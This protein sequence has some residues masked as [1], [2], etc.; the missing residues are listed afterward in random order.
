MRANRQPTR[1]KM[2]IILAHVSSENENPLKKKHFN[3]NNNDNV[4]EVRIFSVVVARQGEGKEKKA[5]VFNTRFL[6]SFIHFYVT[7]KDFLFNNFFFFH[8]LRV[9]HLFLGL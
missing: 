7:S 4:T 6:H 9:S 1:K 5:I 8:K 2:S 3:N